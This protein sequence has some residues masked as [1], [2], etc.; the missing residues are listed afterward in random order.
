MIITIPHLLSDAL[1]DQIVTDLSSLDWLP[2]ETADA[3]YA[4]R[5]KRNEEIKE[6]DN[7][8]AAEYG[9]LLLETMLTNGEL[10]RKALPYKAKVPQFNR[11]SGG[12]FYGKH[13][14]SAFMGSPEIRTDLS[15]TIFLND[16]SEYDGG[17]LTLDFPSGET[18]EIKEAKGTIVCY[19]SEVL[20]YVT[21]VTRGTRYAAITWIQSFIRPPHQRALLASLIALS[22]R[23]KAKEGLSDTY[24][25]LVSV[26]N[27]LLKMWSEF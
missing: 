9:K 22:D 4:S 5:V 2:G 3:E 15:V 27:N 18:R 23:I 25:E 20:H 14:D 21:P 10:R 8:R 26:Q 6:K 11:Y 7:P 13:A 17:E 19:P 12:D 16:P 1:A 24:T